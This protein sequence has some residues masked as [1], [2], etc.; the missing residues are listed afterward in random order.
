MCAI[1]ANLSRCE[2][3]VFTLAER[4]DAGEVIPR[5]KTITALTNRATVPVAISVL[6]QPPCGKN[7]HS[8]NERG[9]LASPTLLSF[10]GA[11]LCMCDFW[12]ETSSKL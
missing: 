7:T 2:Y 11:A 10:A 3:H 12:Y 8:F 9:A 1:V 4:F 6:T 5:E